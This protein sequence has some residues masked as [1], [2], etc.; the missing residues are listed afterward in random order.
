MSPQGTIQNGINPSDEVH[1]RIK[2]LVHEIYN[3]EVEG[4]IDADGEWS[5]NIRHGIFRIDILHPFGEPYIDVAYKY[6]LDD[7]AKSILKSSVRGAIDSS[8]FQHGL[9]NALTF[10]DTFYFM[11]M[12]ESEDGDKIPKGFTVGITL[13]PFS[14]ELSI[15]NLSK[16][17]Q[18]VAG[19]SALGISFFGSKL[20]SYKAFME[21]LSELNSSP[22]EMFQ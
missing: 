10:P 9:R 22:G 3:Q 20:A 1:E 14:G 6:E 19:A 16:A 2:S 7:E 21:F 18:N 8:E 4:R 5:V 13:Y 17:I 12:M 15:D 11:H